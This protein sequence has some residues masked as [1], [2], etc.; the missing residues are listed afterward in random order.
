M[1]GPLVG[2]HRAPDS[3]PPSGLKP[4]VA[5]ENHA[6]EARRNLADRRAVDRA[7][8]SCGHVAG[9]EHRPNVGPIDLVRGA[10]LDDLELIFVRQDLFVC[11]EDHPPL[12]R[13]ELFGDHSFACGP[14]PEGGS[15]E[16]AAVGQP[17]AGLFD[18]GAL[19][20][21][22]GGEH[23][24]AVAREAPGREEHPPARPVRP[25]HDAHVLDAAALWGAQTVVV[26]QDHSVVAKCDTVRR[27]EPV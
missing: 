25:R 12:P 21:G 2:A 10:P 18:P 1:P 20:G 19:I 13:W 16:G 27:D 4:V 23:L 14:Q 26:L 9:R 22:H 6:P 5:A 11:P 17:D 8:A 15:A 3:P 24:P 7:L